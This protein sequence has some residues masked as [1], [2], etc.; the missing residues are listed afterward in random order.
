MV[1]FWDVLKNRQ[2]IRAFKDKKVP[3]E[4]IEK[5]LDAAR[6]APSALNAQPWD[7]VVVT[8]QGI[9]KEIR[10]IYDEAR[11]LRKLYKQDTKFVENGVV[12]VVCSHTESPKHVISTSLAVENLVLAATALELGSVIMTT[13]VSRR[14]DQEEIKELLKIPEVYDLIAIVVIGYADETPPPKSKRDLGE[15]IHVNEF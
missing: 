15:I 12:V 1:D 9:K 5:I 14:V 10:H 11:K 8:D 7:F 13:L 4:T 2:S 6:L 3:M